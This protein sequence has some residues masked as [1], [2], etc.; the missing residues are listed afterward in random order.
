[1][2]NS[3]IDI[4]QPFDRPQKLLR[5]LDNGDGTYSVAAGLS[6]FPTTV[7]GEGAVAEST[8]VLQGTFAYTVDN[9]ELTT[10]TVVG[11]ATITQA[12]GLAVLSSS[13][14]TAN[15]ALLQTRRHARYRAGLG[16][17]SMFTTIFS[18]PVAGTEMLIGL[19]DE[20]GSTAAFK[21]G[22]MVGYIGTVFGFHRFQNDSVTTVA[23]A[24]WDDPLDGTGKS[25]MT[26]DKTKGNVWKIQ[27]QYLGFGAI[28]L[29][30]EDSAT[31]GFTEAHRILYANF[32]TTPSVHNPNFHHTMWV[33][34]KAT[35]SNMVLKS[36]SYAF[37]IEGK[38]RYQEIHQPQQSSGEKQTT[39]VTSE[40]AIVT[41]RNKSSYVSK[42]NFIDVLLE[43]ITASIEAGAANNLAKIRIV[44]NATLGGFPS[45]N[46]ISTSDSVVDFDVAGTTVTGGKE[47]FSTPL[48][49][50]NDKAIIPLSDY[51]FILAPGE[52]VTVAGSSANSAT[53]NASLLW[54][55]LF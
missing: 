7:F 10:N 37:F 3:T 42:T 47:L 4:T 51:E 13:T 41:I 50:K 28:V 19:A 25:G 6:N 55:E 20:T 38:T 32:N 48:A 18:A 46:D 30:V 22:Y 5:I 36:A 17:K 43:N 11:D 21:N 12:N 35:T 23:Q 1:M 8:P 24:D 33:N 2:A 44:R 29:S 9:T 53:I 49:G 31:G 26:L 34:N 52:T 39:T 27:F 45:Y 54:K 16:G 14:T 40:V 15:S